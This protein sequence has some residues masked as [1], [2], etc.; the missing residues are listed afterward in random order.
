MLDKLLSETGKPAMA[1][2]SRMGDRFVGKKPWADS[3]YKTIFDIEKVR[4]FSRFAENE[5]VTL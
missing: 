3:E 4:A 5:R 2:G 1:E